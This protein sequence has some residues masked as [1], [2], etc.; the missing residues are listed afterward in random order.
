[1]QLAEKL[2]NGRGKDGQYRRRRFH[3]D[4]C[5]IYHTVYADGKGD[6]A[7]MRAAVEEAKKVFDI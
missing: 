5:D 2:P 3:C 1:M 7:R 4:I 6:E